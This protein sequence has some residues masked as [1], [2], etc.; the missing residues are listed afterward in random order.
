MVNGIERIAGDDIVSHS[1]YSNRACPAITISDLNKPEY[2]NLPRFKKVKPEDSLKDVKSNPLTVKQYESAFSSQET[3][4]SQKYL[5]M[6]FKWLHKQN[7]FEHFPECQVM[8]YEPDKA[9]IGSDC[10]EA[11]RLYRITE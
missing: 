8:L 5:T 11:L 4:K 7:R 9:L 1:Y 6:I 2:E 10:V 3:M